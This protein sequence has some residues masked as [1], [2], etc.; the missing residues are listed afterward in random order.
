MARR[1]NN[2]RTLKCSFCGRTEH[3]A[4]IMVRGYDAACICETCLEQ[5]APQVQAYRNTCKP[6][7]EPKKVPTPASVKAELDKYV[8]GQE[9]AKRALAV[10]LHAHYIRLRAPKG[11]IRKSNILLAGPTGCGK[12][13]LA[14]ALAKAAQVPFAMT[15]ATTLTQ[16]GYVGE[17]VENVLLRL[18]QAADGDIAKAERGIIYIDEFDKI[19]RKSENPSITRDV[20]GEGVQ[21]ALLKIIEGTVADVPTKGGRKNPYEE[22]LR[23]NTT[24]ILFILGGAF[25]GLDKVVQ[26][27]KELPKGIGFGAVV[28]QEPVPG[29]F[30]PKPEDLIQFGI[31][32][33]LVGRVPIVAML[34][35]L[36]EDALVRVL[37]EP[38]GSIVG[39]YRRLMN[40]DGIELV[41]EDDALRAMAHEAFELGTGARGLRAIIERVLAD[42]LYELPSRGVPCRCLVTKSCV[43][44]GAPTLVTDLPDGNE[45]PA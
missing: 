2:A 36:D 10:A 19:G 35:P 5:L 17:D 16:A 29:V 43:T 39:Q 27:R 22:C 6:A 40:E 14:R 7:C 34:E 41:F 15:D 21:Q 38:H 18:V 42:A 28:E 32:P 26:A 31:I 4:G 37:S 24:D 12:T 9:A 23:V 1:E 8:I 45:I 20:S 30:K 3:Q 44:D 25:V 33:E 13:L 11:T